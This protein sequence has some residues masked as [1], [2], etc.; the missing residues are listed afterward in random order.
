[1]AQVGPSRPSEES[2]PK[3]AMQ[4]QKGNQKNKSNIPATL[5]VRILADENPQSPDARHTLKDVLKDYHLYYRRNKYMYQ[6]ASEMYYNSDIYVFLIPLLLLAAFNTI[7]PSTLNA[8]VINNILG[9]GVV[10]QNNTAAEALTTQIDASRNAVTTMIA[11]ITTFMIGL[12]GKLQWAKRAEKY[13]NVA[14]VYQMLEGEAR[15]ML[16]N[17]KN[18]DENRRQDRYESND[19]EK[20][21]AEWDRFFHDS[22]KNERNALNGMVPLQAYVR[23]RAIRAFKKMEYEEKKEQEVWDGQ[24]KYLTGCGFKMCSRCH[25]F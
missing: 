10:M 12:Q 6:Y 19:T 21:A 9:N 5:S 15:I 8:Q 16:N 20:R 1:M 22:E 14:N 23:K 24:E 17:L 7:L 13:A 2:L 18:T 25:A 4:V 11:A 3:S